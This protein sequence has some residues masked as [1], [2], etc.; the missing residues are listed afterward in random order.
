MFSPVAKCVRKPGCH[1]LYNPSEHFPY[2]LT[3]QFLQCSCE[4]PPSIGI[5]KGQQIRQIT[6]KEEADRNQ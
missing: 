1:L 3:V 4:E 5:Q 2:A 6:G